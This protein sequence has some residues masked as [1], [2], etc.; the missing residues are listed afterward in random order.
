M[1]P[2][3]KKINDKQK[4]NSAII[5]IK[6]NPLVNLNWCVCD[7]SMCLT[8]IWTRR[9]IICYCAKSYVKGNDGVTYHSSCNCCV[10]D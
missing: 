10:D 1:V 7:P 9:I 5:R 8:K 3:G 4:K 2:D 6:C